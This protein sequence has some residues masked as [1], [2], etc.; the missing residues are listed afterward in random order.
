MKK[1]KG[2]KK[3]IISFIIAIIAIIILSVCFYN[4]MLT[5]VDKND[6]K[7][8]SFVVKTGESK[9]TIIQNLKTANLI[10]DDKAA[11]VYIA[12]NNKILFKAGTFTLQRNMGTK[13]IFNTLD[14]GK[15]KEQNGINVT[16]K[17]GKTYT[18]YIS[19]ISKKTKLSEDKFNNL[20]KDKKY[21]QTL[22]D[23]YWFLTNDILNEKL[24]Y[25]LEGY[26]FPDTYNFAVNAKEEDVINTILDNTKVKLDE[27]KK[28]MENNN[29]T[30]HKIMTLASIVELEGKE[31]SDRAGIARVFLNR[32]ESNMT[33]GS[34]VTTYY[35]A[36]K[37]FKEDLTT[38]ELNACNSYNTRGSCFKGLPVGPVS[39]PGITAIEAAISPEENDYLFFVSDKKGKIYF[40]KTNA[41]HEQQ[42]AALKNSGDWYTYE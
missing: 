16:L 36:K 25:A 31:N 19:L 34:D 12:L 21:L 1:Y 27:Y 18:S 11:Y 33:L 37:S 5:P 26:L 20:L 32:I 24:Y 35:A 13:E 8:I 29:L 40:S 4:Y 7:K 42:V 6:N 14:S 22:I 41:E 3:L 30:I 23:K 10:K 2:L 28:E 9:K 15:T 17:E 39:N 38:V